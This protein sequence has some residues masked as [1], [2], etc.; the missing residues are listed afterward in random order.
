L[1]VVSVEGCPLETV[2]GVV[3]GITQEAAALPE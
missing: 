3:A 2:V 1:T